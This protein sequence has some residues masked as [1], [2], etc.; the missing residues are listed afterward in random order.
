MYGRPPGFYELACLEQADLVYRLAL[1]QQKT[2]GGWAQ[3]NQ[4]HPA[5]ARVLEEAAVAARELGL[6]E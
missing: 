5:A 4:E 6:L 1:A 3:W 2:P